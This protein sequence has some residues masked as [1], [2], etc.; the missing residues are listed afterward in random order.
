[1]LPISLFQTVVNIAGDLICNSICPSL[2]ESIES[3]PLTTGII[4]AQIF[5]D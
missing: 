2:L 1:M 3:A 4:A 5:L